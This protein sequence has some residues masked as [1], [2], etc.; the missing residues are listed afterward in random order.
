[1]CCKEYCTT[2][3]WLP[4]QSIRSVFCFLQSLLYRPQ[5]FIANMK[6]LESERQYISHSQEVA[7]T[8]VMVEDVPQLR[9]RCLEE[10]KCTDCKPFLRSS[11]SFRTTHFLICRASS[12]GKTLQKNHFYKNHLKLLLVEQSAVLVLY[13]MIRITTKIF[14]NILLHFGSYY[15]SLL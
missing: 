8:L 15:E 12:L 10:T 11:T 4:V 9:C 13:Q 3:E 5:N 1:M 14:F 7:L 6:G 2:N